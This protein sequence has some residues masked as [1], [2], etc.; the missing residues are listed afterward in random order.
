MSGNSTPGN[1]GAGSPRGAPSWLKWALIAS[2]A[3]NLLIIGG[4]IGHHFMGP[5]GHPWRGEG[6]GGDEMGIMGYVRKLPAERRAE[7]SKIVKSGRPDVKVLR[8]DIRKARIGAAEALSAEPFD[9]EKVRAALGAIGAAETRLKQASSDSFLAAAGQMTAE[10][11]SGL[12]AWWKKRRPHQFREPRE[13][14]GK[15]RD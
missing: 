13:D 10:E 12:V 14:G 9:R 2:L 3:V 11:R 6:R 4:A 5:H 7:L 15:K 8:E 1:A